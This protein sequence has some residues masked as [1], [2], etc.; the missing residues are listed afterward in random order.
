MFRGV[1]EAGPD[2]SAFIPCGSHEQWYVSAESVQARE[3][4]RLT[5]T[6]DM[7]PPEGGLR[8]AERAA[9]IRRSYAE[10]QG[11]TVDVIQNGPAIAYDRELRVTRV[12]VVRTSQGGVC[13]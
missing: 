7:L 8:V 12:L 2:R 11:D 10:V 4:R 3:L 5:I 9:V 6:Q 13:Q 1:Y